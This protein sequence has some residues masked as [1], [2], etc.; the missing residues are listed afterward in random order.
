M[1]PGKISPGACAICAKKGGRPC[2]F[3]P[4][5]PVFR[6]V[7]MPAP[8]ARPATERLRHPTAFA[9]HP[10]EIRDFPGPR[11][12]IILGPNEPA[13]RLSKSIMQTTAHFKYQRAGGPTWPPAF[14]YLK[15]LSPA[16]D[17][18]DAIP[19]GTSFQAPTRPP[20]GNCMERNQPLTPPCTQPPGTTQAPP[21][22]GHHLPRPPS[23]P[24]SEQPKPC[25]FFLIW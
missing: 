23:K 21:V 8:P 18:S 11:S 6:R 2:G 17:H 12:F 10:Q 20:A 4:F 16:G 9:S 1:K 3:P 22:A 7:V 13:L 14:S 19:T 24:L 15:T 5:F 25:I